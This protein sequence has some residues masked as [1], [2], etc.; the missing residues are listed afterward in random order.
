MEFPWILLPRT[1]STVESAIG[2]CHHIKHF[3]LSK[4][5]QFQTWKQKTHTSSRCYKWSCHLF[6]VFSVNYQQ[7]M[8]CCCEGH[9]H[10]SSVSHVLPRSSYRPTSLHRSLN[11]SQMAPYY[12][13]LD[14]VKCSALHREWGG[15]WG[16]PRVWSLILFWWV[17]G[18]DHNTLIWVLLPCMMSDGGSYVM[19]ASSPG[20][21]QFDT[22]PSGSSGSQV[23]VWFY[24]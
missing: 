16:K 18:P 17:V 1:Q 15:I 10:Q 13:L 20:R 22:G 8:T 21:V 3:T 19:S 5:S 23:G 9:E 2:R 7:W 6:W 24:S 14:L 11:T 12:S 4:S